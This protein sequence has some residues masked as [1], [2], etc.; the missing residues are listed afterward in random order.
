MHHG[1]GAQVIF[2][3]DGTNEIV[4]DGMDGKASVL[5]ADDAAGVYLLTEM[6]KAKK[7][8]RY[9]FFVGEECGGLG[10]SFYVENNPG[11]SADM[12]VSFDR[13]ALSSVITHQGYSRTCSDV[14]AEALSTA[15]NLQNSGFE[16][17]PDD[18]G[19]YTDS[20]E[21]AHIVPECTNI[22]VGYYNEHTTK[23]LLDLPHL[24]ELTA[25]CIAVDW[26]ALPIDRE[27]EPELPWQASSYSGMYNTYGSKP[28]YEFGGDLS[29]APQW[30]TRAEA[31]EA[32]K[33]IETMVESGIV[34]EIEIKHHLNIIKGYLL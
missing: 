28:S 23:E 11:F 15:L 7:P 4:A 10:S 8:G 33:E 30:R 5:G 26:H 20:K 17:K 34:T 6:I 2:V 3:I 27:P 9:L 19:V 18:G 12:V 21:F 14:Y 32:I 1:D 29:D 31:K 16:Y 22:S 25:A 13:K 24:L